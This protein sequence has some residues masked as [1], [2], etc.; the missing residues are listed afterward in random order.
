V[1]E[2]EAAKLKAGIKGNTR[3]VSVDQEMEMDMTEVYNWCIMTISGDGDGHDGGVSQSDGRRTWS[4][5]YQ[6]IIGI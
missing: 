2:A 1:A 6:Y 3:T 4:A 5:C